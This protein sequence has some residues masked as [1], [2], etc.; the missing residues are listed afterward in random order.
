MP[1]TVAVIGNCQSWGMVDCLTALCPQTTFSRF[2]VNSLRNEQLRLEALPALKQHDLI[3][4]QNFTDK[5]FGAFSRDALVQ[6]FSNVTFFPQIMFGGFHPDD[7]CLEL[8]GKPLKSPIGDHHSLLLAAGFRLGIPPERVI[9]L[10]NAYVFARLGY[11]DEFELSRSVLLSHA[12]DLGYDLSATLDEWLAT[13]VFMHM[14]HHPSIRVLSDV[15]K[16]VAAKAGIPIT[17]S[18]NKVPDRLKQG[19]V[20]PVYPPL[21]RRLGLTGSTSFKLSKYEG[22]G[23]DSKLELEEFIQKSYQMYAQYPRKVFD[24]PRLHK[25]RTVLQREYM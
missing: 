9:N 12:S 20:L 25:A 17:G 6:E 13:G 23:R 8:D 22:R 18:T 11:F 21:A 5:R 14:P 10:F 3:L 16:K 24:I 15:A 2:A 4:A 19:V 7:Y 1:N